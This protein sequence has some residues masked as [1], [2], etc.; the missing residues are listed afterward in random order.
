M[1][2]GVV[3]DRF[4]CPRSEPGDFDCRVDEVDFLPM[5]IIHVILQSNPIRLISMLFFSCDSQTGLN[6]RAR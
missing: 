2:G 5:N 6:T 1:L 4:G 3:R